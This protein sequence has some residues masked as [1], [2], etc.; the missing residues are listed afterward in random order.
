MP[1]RTL[2][3]VTIS[4]I[5]VWFIARHVDLHETARLLASARVSYVLI[6]IV[7]YG[8]GQVWSAYRWRLIGE[9]VGLHAPFAEYVRF[10][11]IGMFF[12]FFGPSTLGGDFARSLY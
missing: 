4:A 6:A 3:Q 2:V 11:F 1:W 7:L 8:I 5:A 10:Y 12:M 9:S